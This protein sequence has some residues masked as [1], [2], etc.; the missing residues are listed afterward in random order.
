M[1][2]A[3]ILH[4]AQFPGRRQRQPLGLDRIEK[5]ARIDIAQFEAGASVGQPLRGQGRPLA[6]RDGEGF[7]RGPRRPLGARQRSLDAR[8]VQQDRRAHHAANRADVFDHADARGIRDRRLGPDAR[9]GGLDR[10]RVG[11][12]ART[13]RVRIG[14]R[15]GRGRR[16]CAD[17]TGDAGE[18]G[19]SRRRFEAIRFSRRPGQSA[20]AQPGLGDRVAKPRQRDR[21]DSRACP[22]V[23]R[24][25]GRVA[26]ALGAASDGRAPPRPAN[27]AWRKP[28]HR[29][30]ERTRGRQQDH[31]NGRRAARDAASV[32]ALQRRLASVHGDP[33]EASRR[34]ASEVGRLEG[35][36]QASRQAVGVR[37]SG[38]S[39]AARRRQELRRRDETGFE[40]PDR[41]SADRRGRARNTGAISAGRPRTCQPG[42]G[43]DY[44]RTRRVVADALGAAHPVL[45]SLSS[46]VRVP[47]RLIR[48]ETMLAVE[49]LAFW[50]VW[51]WYVHRLSDQSDEAWGIAALVTAVIFAFWQRRESGSAFSGH[52][53]LT[54]PATLLLCYSLSYHFLSPLPR[55]AIAV[56]AIAAT[57]SA[58]RFGRRL[59]LGVWGLLLLAL[60]VVASLQFYL[61]F[62]MRAVVARLA[63]PMLQI[64][65]FVVTAV[66]ASLNW[67]GDPIL[68]DA[69][70]SGV[71]TL[72]TG[73]YLTFTLA[74]YYKLNAKRTALACVVV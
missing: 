65:G 38:E 28:D 33:L 32:L 63:A 7:S 34:P 68:I 53:R 61:G 9:P 16:A 73:F 44:S 46:E 41:H 12:N 43:S 10:G 15:V 5:A 45:D 27:A 52:L 19:G 11:Q 3:A 21:L 37:R 20:R 49:L 47:S 23:V 48:A 35:D 50:P 13:W 69:P 57:V 51:R 36:L 30:L 66:G 64:N 67:N 39:A 40:L 25:R 26:S 31:A 17:A 14:G 62:P 42:H 60:P 29:K 59:H 71:K 22:G 18:R 24:F 55:A 56:T 1:D 70:C 54:L 58:M 2:A 74:C 6:R 72:W 8:C 4:R